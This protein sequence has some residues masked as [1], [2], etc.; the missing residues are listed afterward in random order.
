MDADLNLAIAGQR[1]VNLLDLEN[2]GAAGLVELHDACHV[3][4]LPEAS[5]PS[6]NR[7]HSRWP[8]N[9]GTW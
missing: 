7:L 6:T 9:P 1:D 3:A 4:H 5:R 2:L 8:G